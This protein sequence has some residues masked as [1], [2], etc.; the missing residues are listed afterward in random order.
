[1]L[2]FLL[3]KVYVRGMGYFLEINITSAIGL[4]V[5]ALLGFLVFGFLVSLG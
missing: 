1:M 5:L 2:D 3:G 4:I